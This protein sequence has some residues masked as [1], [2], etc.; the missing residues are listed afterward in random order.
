MPEHDFQKEVIDRLARIETKQDAT[1]KTVADHCDDIREQ[2]IKIATI[3][4]SSKS[5]HRRIDGIYI[6]AGAIGGA[7]GWI[8]DKFL[9]LF[10]GRGGS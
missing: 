6:T 2:G 9:S 5:A 10:Q 4:A 1:M 8:V 3:E 7:A